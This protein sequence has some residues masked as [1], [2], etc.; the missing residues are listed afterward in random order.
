[1]VASDLRQKGEHSDISCQSGVN[2]LSSE[3]RE[4]GIRK[5]SKPKKDLDAERG[6]R[7]S[8]ADVAVGYEVNAETDDGTVDG[9][10]DRAST[11]FW[12]TYRF[13]E[14]EQKPANVEGPPR[15]VWSTRLH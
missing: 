5:Q 8:I 15:W 4:Q 14:I 11:P 3:G 13:L 9:D 12:G 6:V 7:S 10:Y 1:M 2:F